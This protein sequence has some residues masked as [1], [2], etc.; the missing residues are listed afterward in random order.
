[1]FESKGMIVIDQAAA[2]EDKV[3]EIALE[4]GAEDVR[5]EGGQY[6]ITCAP[7]SFEA[8]REKITAAG[9]KKS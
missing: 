7:E 9:I 5:T 1:M 3:Y 6:E 8:L 2:E 4:N